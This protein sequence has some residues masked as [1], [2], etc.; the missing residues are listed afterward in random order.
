[1]PSVWERFV[2]LFRRGPALNDR[3]KMEAL[4]F[5]RGPKAVRRLGTIGEMRRT[6]AAASAKGS[7]CGYALKVLDEYCKLENE[8]RKIELPLRA[9]LTDDDEV[10][11]PLDVHHIIPPKH[12][13]GY[14]VEECE[15]GFALETLETLNMRWTVLRLRNKIIAID[16][17][18]LLRQEKCGPVRLI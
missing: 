15:D 8:W 13:I 3:I 1:M 10:G 14:A 5:S 4:W 11:D 2:G 18:G 9:K 7:N 12:V 16:S 17:V 6:I